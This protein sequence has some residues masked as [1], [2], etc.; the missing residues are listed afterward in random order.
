MLN[1]DIISYLL[2]KDSTEIQYA[3]EYIVNH[4]QE[5]QVQEFLDG[6]IN[7]V[8]AHVASLVKHLAQYPWRELFKYISDSD[9]ISDEELQRK[10]LD[11]AL[12]NSVS[13][14][15][16]EIDESSRGLLQSLYKRLS[17]ITDE[18]AEEQTR[19]IFSILKDANIVIEDL[20]VVS[21]PLCRYIIENS[22]YKITDSNLRT[23]L[24]ISER[25]VLDRV[26]KNEKV[27]NFCK[28][29]IDTYL[30]TMQ[31]YSEQ[32]HSNNDFIFIE[33]TL[34]SI[35]NEQHGSW[36][37][38]QLCAIIQ[39]SSHRANISDIH[40]V[41][42]NLW[43]PIVDKKLMIPTVNNIAGYIE[44]FGVDNHMEI[45]CSHIMI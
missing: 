28:K 32:H 2:K 25:P 17:A 22:M 4:I 35:L 16:Y 14:E 13:A 24:G 34:I 11:Y 20:E 5:E 18:H 31:E 30:A 3:I 43:P 44:T 19:N 23:A 29:N 8:K 42:E 33:D 41:L 12:L 39:A 45:I 36:T 40:D 10:V 1:V 37:E 38:E 9:K 26:I 15:L 27:W 21:E 6:F 7:G